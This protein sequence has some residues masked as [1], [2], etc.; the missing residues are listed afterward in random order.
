MSFR[1][2]SGIAEHE[3]FG[4]LSLAAFGLWVKAGAWTS[5]H[6]SPAF[7]PVRALE[8]ICGGIEV[9]GEVDEVVA[10][11]VWTRV[12]D[13]Y[14]MEYGPGNDIPRLVWRYD[15]APEDR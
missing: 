6:Q 12:R 5:V 14:R 9:S 10:A 8:E 2:V 11:G 1:F 15:D 4:A 13:G 7:V 3:V